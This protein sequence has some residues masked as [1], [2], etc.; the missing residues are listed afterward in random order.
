[1]QIFQESEQSQQFKPE[2]YEITEE[3]GLPYHVSKSLRR[4]IQREDSRMQK[5][6]RN[7]NKRSGQL[8][9]KEKR[10]ERAKI[11][12]KYDE[13]MMH[14][15]EIENAQKNNYSG[16]TVIVWRESS[17]IP[18]VPQAPWK[19]RQVIAGSGSYT[20][21]KSQKPDFLIEYLYVESVYENKRKELTSLIQQSL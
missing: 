19:R 20:S 13:R 8:S 18:F 17:F 10:Q 16:I 1:M 14:G 21:P 11:M 2:V 5:E 9:S 3:K 7:F 6:W 4:S 12:K 15:G